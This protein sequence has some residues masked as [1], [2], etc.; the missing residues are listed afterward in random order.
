MVSRLDGENLFLMQSDD[1]RLWEDPKLLQQPKF[2]WELVQIGN[3]GSPMEI[4]EGWLLLRMGS[5]RC[6]SIA[7]GPR[8]WI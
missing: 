4:K 7:L 8:F 3:C 6:G 5:V 2:Y 1:V